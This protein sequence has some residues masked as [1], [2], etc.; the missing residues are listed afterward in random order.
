MPSVADALRGRHETAPYAGRL[1]GQSH[2]DDRHHHAQRLLGYVL[3]AGASGRSYT[4]RQVFTTGGEIQVYRRE[5]V[6]ITRCLR[7]WP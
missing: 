5:A 3:A 4:G 1:C 7:W 2:V 6:V